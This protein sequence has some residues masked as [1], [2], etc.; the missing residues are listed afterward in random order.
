MKRR[1][2]L[3]TLGA[4]AGAGVA[5]R[6]LPSCG[7]NAEEPQGITNI[8]C[9]MMENRSYDHLFGARKLLEGKPGDGLMAGM[10][11]PDLDGNPVGIYE[12]MMAGMCVPDPP[13]GWD[14]SHLQWSD[15]T[16]Q[17]FLRE[18][19]HDKGDDRTLTQVMEYLTRQHVPV[20]WA[21]ADAYATCDRYFCSVMGPTWPNRMFWH[22]GDSGG[23]TANE[24]PMTG[25]NW[26]SI[27]HRLDAKGVGWRY[28]YTD[29]PVLALIDTLNK[30]GK[31]WDISEF[32][33]DAMYGRLQPVTYVDPG[34][35]TND[36]HPPHHPILGQQFLASVYTAL[37]T[38]PQ[39]KNTLMVV[40]Y[41]EHGG[42]FDHV[43]PPKTTGDARA[44]QGFDQLGFRVPTMIIGPYVKPG[45]VSSVT[46]DHCSVLRHIEKMFDLE[47]C[48]ARTAA[49]TDLSDAIDQEALASFQP[50]DPV[51][52]P[53]VTVDESMIGDECKTTIDVRER[54]DLFRMA[55]EHPEL[56][57]GY[58]LRDRSRETIT[59]IG[60]Y[61]AAHGAG[62]IHWGR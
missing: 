25:F 47:P 32:Y 10:S 1:E 54:H 14:S 23:L 12:A 55:E 51:Q 5:S 21:I 41:D 52:V 2:A 48:N 29:L 44:D 37:A 45:Y 38:S 18:F 36:D 28:Y 26:P 60:E 24:F 9:V 56:F 20:S 27:Y 16:N 7:D 42:F 46:Y 57:R 33:A 50:R 13:H 34:F 31:V 49:A 15:M 4:L 40:T 59:M 43:S 19:Q 11:N 35:G 39:W 3:K 17:G 22:S 61:L 58:D 8:V 53:S 30:E 62:G 6:V